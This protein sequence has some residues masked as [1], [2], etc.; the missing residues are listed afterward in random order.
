M[1]IIQNITVNEKKELLEKIYESF[2]TGFDFETFLKPFLEKL[3]LKEVTITK[4]T[5]DGGIDL[6]GVM[7][8]LA[9]LNGA[10]EVQYKI[11]AKRNNPNTTISPEKIDALRG[12]LNF[13]QKGLFITTA[14]VTDKAKEDAQ[15]KD[16]SKPVIVIDGSM[17][18]D[19]CIQK[20]ICCAY[21]PIFS[22]DA[23][24]SFILQNNNDFEYNKDQNSIYNNKILLKG[25]S[26]V[27][28]YNDIRAR[29]ISVP[30]FIVLK[31][32][33]NNK[34]HFVNVQINNENS[35]RSLTFNPGR[36]Y[37]GS[38]TDILKKYNLIDKDGSYNPKNAIWTIDTCNDI[39]YLKIT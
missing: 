28:S 27:I 37:L 24:K 25:V 21:K 17:L 29:I 13:N 26:K 5:G 1:R 16:P 9:E 20:Q 4:K 3:G 2:E 36:N 19:I 22:F 8:G 6:L 32:K 33:N 31:L 7:P 12:N 18:V 11:Q 39:I 30:A 34:K 10:D 35:I 14:K 23:M 38:V 15:I